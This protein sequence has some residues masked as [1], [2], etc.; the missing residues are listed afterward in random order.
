MC[1]NTQGWTLQKSMK[2]NYLGV[3][4]QKQTTHIRRQTH[5]RLHDSEQ[6]SG[7]KAGRLNTRNI[8]H[9][10]GRGLLI[11]FWWP[12]RNVIVLFCWKVINQM[13]NTSSLMPLHPLWIVIDNE[14]HYSTLK[15]IFKLYDWRRF[16]FTGSLAYKKRLWAE[17]VSG[18]T[19]FQHITRKV[20]NLVPGIKLN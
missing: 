7:R 9:T 1:L 6:A 2:N 13:L 12:Q 10:A 15:Y 3:R 4:T 17:K 20:L 14:V 19:D 18:V 5:V 16:I 8:I 11:K